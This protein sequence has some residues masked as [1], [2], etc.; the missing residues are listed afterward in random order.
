M[1]PTLL[2]PMQPP[3]PRAG[4]WTPRLLAILA[5]AFLAGIAIRIQLLPLAGYQAD[6]DEFVRWVNRL[7]TNGLGRHFDEQ[8][9]F[10]PVMAYLWWIQGALSPVFQTVTNAGDPAIRALMKVPTLIVDLGLASLLAVFF[11]DRP[12]RAIAAAA[13]VLLN[14]AI[15]FDS[16]WWGQYESVYTISIVAAF[17]LAAD[18]RELS[19]AVM[20]AI[21]LM[22]KP[23]A[24]P[25]LLPFAAWFFATGGITTIVRAT[26]A[27]LLTILVLWVPFIPYNGP[28]NYLS[29]LLY[30]QNER[31]PY[32]SYGAWNL[33]WYVQN[34][35]GGWV[36]D[37]TLVLGPLSARF[38]GYALAGSLSLVAA[39]SIWRLRTPRA[40]ALGLA[41]TALVEYCFLTT[42]HERYSY[43]AIVLL[44][45]VV[46]DW[47]A[48]ALAASLSFVYVANL[49]AAASN[50][51]YFQ[52]RVDMG[53]SNGF[54]GSGAM[55]AI[56]LL[57]LALA[58]LPAIRRGPDREAQGA[59]A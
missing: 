21:A 28:S 57:T 16:A 59:A 9:S 55:I 32:M 18:R 51:G 6:I 2:P 50:Q 49:A 17:V 40:L 42:M 25:L 37:D 23:Q 11:R 33:W 34:S 3:E 47:R 29:S 45:L 36:R 10:G 27:G 15:W 30:F 39:W 19:T 26:A 20:L 52:P 43:P 24:L 22:T 12:W 46:Y 1:P 44:L 54:L 35:I 41:A 31:F 56:T 13:I 48:L 7:A 38:V 58:A 4:G 5:G 14:P 53:G 8:Q